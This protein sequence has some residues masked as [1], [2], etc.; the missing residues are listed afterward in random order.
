MRKIFVNRAADKGFISKYTNR[1]FSSISKEKTIKNWL[2]D[3][4]R[5]FSKEDM[6]LF[7]KPQ[8]K[9]TQHL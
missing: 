4:N 3:L 5:Y 2:E 6:Q 8:W 1:S 9:H 7:K